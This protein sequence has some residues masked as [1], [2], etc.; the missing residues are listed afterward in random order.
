MKFIISA[1]KVKSKSKRN[2]S[3]GEQQI[4]SP[5][6]STEHYDNKHEKNS[7]V[8]L[9]AEVMQKAEANIDDSRT[10]DEITVNVISDKKGNFC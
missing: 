10:I 1:K 4:N 3:K 5:I 6:E 8:Q 2:K 9:T 7:P